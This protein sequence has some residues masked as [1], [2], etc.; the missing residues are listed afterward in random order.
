MFLVSIVFFDAEGSY[1]NVKK[2][3]FKFKKG[4]K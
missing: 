4:I 2:R 3:E 1:K